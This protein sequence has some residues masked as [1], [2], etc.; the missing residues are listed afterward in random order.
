MDKNVT[1]YHQIPLNRLLKLHSVLPAT[2]E[3]KENCIF[4]VLFIISVEDFR[5]GQ[6]SVC[7]DS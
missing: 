6:F 4:V 5:A 7:E 2:M 1:V 3:T